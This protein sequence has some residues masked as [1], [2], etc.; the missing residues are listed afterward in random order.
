MNEVNKELVEN[1]TKMNQLYKQHLED[2]QRMNQQW[3][4]LFLRPF[5][6]QQGQHQEQK[7]KQ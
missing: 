7:K 5:I 2:M 6:G 3:F 4:N 1:Y